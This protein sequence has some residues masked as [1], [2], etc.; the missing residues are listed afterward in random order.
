MTY[1]GCEQIDIFKSDDP[2]V[3]KLRE[4]PWYST[5]CLLVKRRVLERIGGFDEN[6]FI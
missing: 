1:I 4:V 6:L 3:N 2:E 5:T